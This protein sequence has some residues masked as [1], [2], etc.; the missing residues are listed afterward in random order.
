MADIQACH[1]KRKPSCFVAI[2]EE[3]TIV[4]NARWRGLGILSVWAVY[5]AVEEDLFLEHG[6]IMMWHRC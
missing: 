1:S 2:T 5:G 6:A 4:L 3:D